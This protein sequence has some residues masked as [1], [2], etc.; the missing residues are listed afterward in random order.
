MSSD[1]KELVL[2]LTWRGSR[3][4]VL[5]V[6]GNKVLYSDLCD[7]CSE[8]SR[9]KATSKVVAKFPA[10][11]A[12]DIDAQLLA[13]AR[14]GPE[15]DSDARSGPPTIVEPDPEPWDAAVDGAELL[16][17]IETLLS[18]H[19]VLPAHGGVTAALWILHSY[20]FDRFTCT[21]RLLLASAVMRSGKTLLLRLV[22]AL[23]ARALTTEG[24]S[25]PALFRI[26]EAVRP[27]I[28]ADEADTFLTPRR[29]ASESS[30]ALRGV[31]NSGLMRG[32]RV[33]RCQ[34]ENHEPTA[35]STH[36]PMVI[37]GI[38]NPPATVLD[39]SIVL[40]MRRRSAGEKVARIRPGRLL[41]EQHRDI[42]RRCRRWADDHADQVA[43][44]EPAIPT[45]LNDRQADLW[46]PLLVLADAVGG[47]WSRLAR[48]AAVALSAAPADEEDN[49]IR[50]LGDLRDVFGDED[51]LPTAEVLRRLVALD[52]APWQTWHR[53]GPLTSHGLARLLR[54]FEVRPTTI[55]I[56]AGT[57]KG[58]R[59]DDLADAFS[60]YLSPQ[61]GRELATPTQP[62]IDKALER[63]RTETA[64]IDVADSDVRNPLSG[65]QCCGVAAPAVGAGDNLDIKP[66]ETLRGHVEQLAAVLDDPAT[67]SPDTGADAR[68]F[69]RVHVRECGI[70]AAIA[71]VSVRLDA[72]REGCPIPLPRG[73]TP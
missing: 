20:V 6:D 4:Q 50:L 55:R 17:D 8:L 62:S 12:D 14:R 26:I 34:G 61:K 31:V 69:Y 48:D 67:E 9:K 45:S 36:A 32:G 2:E 39:R 19:V 27:T 60:R 57:P 16:H 38:G 37:A 41:R 1:P 30:E 54:P 21:P 24:I 63:N 5:I 11:D 46:W 70:D 58:Y 18:R 49:S 42:A 43:E 73:T 68:E 47:N 25:A 22:A 72:A 29:D 7:P 44:A 59:L 3:V 35:F 15:K 23:V 53:G 40:R 28:L 10:L 56:G 13:V 64:G 51:K 52:S 33:V 66:M 71:D 65:S